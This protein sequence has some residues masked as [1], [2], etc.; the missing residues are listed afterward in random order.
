MRATG[1]LS[2]LA[3]NQPATESSSP[4]SSMRV[5]GRRPAHV[6]DRS[7]VDEHGLTLSAPFPDS[8]A[9]PAA[10]Q[11]VALLFVDGP[12]VDSTPRLLDLLQR[13]HVP[14]TFFATGTRILRAPELIERIFGEGHELGNGTLSR[15][16]VDP[17][18]S[19]RLRLEL[20][21]TSRLLEL[22]IGRR[23]RLLRQPTSTK[24]A[25]AAGRAWLRR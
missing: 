14:A 15:A 1:G 5:A 19:I 21:A 23:P 3:W 4:P 25:P 13:H 24:P 10:P 12:D 20:E 8:H 6:R 17:M 2:D 16:L 7:I 18:R 22:L 11:R 9:T